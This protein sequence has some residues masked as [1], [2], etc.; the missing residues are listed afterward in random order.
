MKKK[1][2][3]TPSSVV[4]RRDLTVISPN[5]FVRV[6]EKQNVLRVTPTISVGRSVKCEREDQPQQRA[7]Q[8]TNGHYSQDMYE[9]YK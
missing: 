5:H 7:L 6:V 8:C 3:H 2:G 4:V 9:N 1:Q